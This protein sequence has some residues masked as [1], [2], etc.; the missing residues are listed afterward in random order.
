ML[1]IKNML[2]YLIE[3]K[4]RN[5][6]WCHNSIKSLLD[7]AK[8]R[9]ISI[10]EIHNNKY[11]KADKNSIVFILGGTTNWVENSIQ[12]AIENNYY[13]ITM[14]N[15]M[16]VP[17]GDNFSSVSLDIP[18]ATKIGID[19]LYSLGKNK[20][21]LY[22]VNDNSTSDPIRESVFV[23]ITGMKTD[24]YRFKN[25]YENMF[26]SLKK[27][28]SKYDAIL[29]CNDF[30]SFSLLY[31]LKKIGIKV[32]QDIYIV[33]MGLAN[34]TKISHP[35]ITTLSD[36]FQHFGNVAMNIVKNLKTNNYISSMDIRLPAKLIIRESTDNKPFKQNKKKRNTIKETNNP[37]F[38]DKT[39]S[40]ILKL[41]I[42]LENCDDIDYKII[43]FI[44]NNDTYS[45]IAEK[46]YVAETTIKYRIKKMK[47][48]CGVKSRSE[49]S[50]FLRD[51]L[52]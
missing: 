19:Y 17:N 45:Y 28:I 42:L 24:V 41:E 18:M 12:K 8:K 40:N 38:E 37:F 7:E 52:S 23:K 13:P 50:R 33:G 21:A 15:R 5:F 11:P 30:A 9:R 29:C 25:S 4:Y 48:I 22:G 31:N 49:L 27:N 26:N 43:S 51:Y 36:D 44:M 16:L 3:N 1:I 46:C 39:V 6:P 35:S 2:Y 14:A 34:M 20:I 10:K 32:P 47:N